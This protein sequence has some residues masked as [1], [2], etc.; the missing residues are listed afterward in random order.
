MT[1]KDYDLESSKSKIDLLDYI[2]HNAGGK[3]V[4][5]GRDKDGPYSRI[6]PC[7]ICGRNDHF[8]VYKDTNS[9][10]S[11]SGCCS[12]GTIVDFLQ[13]HENLNL[14]EAIQKT[15][16]LAGVARADFTPVKNNNSSAT[17]TPNPKRTYDFTN[18]AEEL[19]KNINSTNYFKSRGLSEDIIRKYKL[20]YHERGLNYVND[21]AAGALAEKKNDFYKTYQYFIPCLD[22]AGKCYYI[23]P[24]R[25]DEIPAPTWVKSKVH[26]V[27]NLKGYSIA[28]FNSRYLEDPSLTDR[29][30]FVVEGWADALSLEELGYNAMSINS[31]NNVKAFIGLVKKNKDL[32]KEKTFI[33]AGDADSAGQGMNLN[34][35]KGLQALK[36]I[37]FDTFIITQNKDLNQW[38]TSDKQG[39][40]EDLEKYIKQLGTKDLNNTEKGIFDFNF[41]DVGNAE[42][43][44]HSYGGLIKFSFDRNKWYIWSGR[45]WALDKSGNI[46]RMA[47]KVIRKIQEEAELLDDYD[48]YEKALKKQVKSFVI[49]SENDSRIKA[50]INQTKSQWGVAVKEETLD[51]DIYVL[52]CQSGMLNLKTGI[53]MPHDKEALITKI[54]PVEYNPE[55]KCP[56]W[57][58]FLD[59]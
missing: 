33:L 46:D 59:R 24:R 43:L 19:H 57:L 9:Y 29:Y 11:R 50:M 54:S 16:D 42:R 26:K 52:N 6:N 45:K 44:I 23:L 27:H 15:K 41:S 51:K 2:L 17:A 32:L 21:T 47:K 56:N 28:I 5:K 35:K 4:Y 55:A 49:K 20:G 37:Q 10:C 58:K 40:K 8:D 53:L 30:I 31:T 1:N 12:G 3:I 22:A 36:N 48:E 39:L 25:N 38:L 13:E 34:I 7:P 18:V 14:S